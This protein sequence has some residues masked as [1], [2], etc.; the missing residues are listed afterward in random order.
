V[1]GHHHK[2]FENNIDSTI[3]DS[4]P[5]YVL[6][7]YSGTGI[8]SHVLS[9]SEIYKNNIRNNNVAIGLHPMATYGSITDIEVRENFLFKNNSGIVV[10]PWKDDEYYYNNIEILSNNILETTKESPIIFR[11]NGVKQSDNSILYNYIWNTSATNNKFP[12]YA[13][14]NI[15]DQTNMI[16]RGNN[17]KGT[18]ISHNSRMINLKNSDLKLNNNSFTSHCNEMEQATGINIIDE[19][20]ITGSEN[21]FAGF[22]G[23]KNLLGFP[24]DSINKDE[25]NRPECQ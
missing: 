4:K 7:G 24:D 21:S 23:N 20:V 13:V 15:Q 2:V 14:L 17:I 3:T 8:K 16:V 12:P 25:I 1:N 10:E 19:V 18:P 11:G 22:I 9:S 5:S 6:H